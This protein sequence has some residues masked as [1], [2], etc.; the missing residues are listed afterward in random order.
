MQ[1]VESLETAPLNLLDE[2]IVRDHRNKEKQ[3]M[4]EILE[5]YPSICR[6]KGVNLSNII[7]SQICR[8]I[9]KVISGWKL[10]NVL[11][12]ESY[13]NLQIKDYDSVDFIL[14]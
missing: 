11:K 4:N 5:E 7:H 13:L 14:T 10:K 1:W 8:N 2:R 6:G 12:H 9:L 3:I